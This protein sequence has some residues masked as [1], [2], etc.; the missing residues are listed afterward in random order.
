MNRSAQ[1]DLVSAARCLAL[2][3]LASRTSALFADAGIPHLLI[4]G[5]ST[6][7]WLYPDNPG[8]RSYSDV[9]LLVRAD[10]FEEAQQLLHSNGYQCK[11]SGLRPSERSWHEATWYSPNAEHLPVDLHRSFP[12]VGSATVY[13]D[14]LWASSESL[15]V[16]GRTIA[17]PDRAGAALIVA[18]HAVYPGFGRRKPLVDLARALD[19]F[20]TTVWRMAAD[21]AR[22][23]NAESTF[24]AGLGLLADGQ[25]KLD[26]LQL[27][28]PVVL[29]EWLGGRHGNPLSV[30]LAQ[31]HAAS[32]LRERVL[33]PV[34][35]LLPSPAWIRLRYGFAGRGIPWLVAGYVRGLPASC[36]CSLGRFL[37]SCL[38][39]DRFARPGRSRLAVDPAPEWTGWCGKSIGTGC[40]AP[41]GPCDH[42]SKRES[43]FT[44][45][46]CVMCG[47]P[48]RPPC[49]RRTGGS[50]CSC[51]GA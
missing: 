24:R 27:D 51:C 28:G 50:W 25:R 31:L 34:S 14:L 49:V 35:R 42:G 48:R 37:R 45:A 32:G 23:C 15:S 1:A 19:V 13:F 17:I 10:R 5:Q 47:C 43:N 44:T 8:V 7:H 33:R 4:K 2:D 21:L 46:V 3:V 6:G 29:S 30:R 16:A 20:D 36:G 26:E 40:G 9:D 11:Q 12:G 22:E 41:G 18:M 39:V 38:R